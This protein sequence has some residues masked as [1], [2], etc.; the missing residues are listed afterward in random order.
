MSEGFTDFLLLDLISFFVVQ[1]A[2]PHPLPSQFA[3]G[4]SAVRRRERKTATRQISG[5]GGNKLVL[6]PPN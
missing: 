1:H 6:F 4:S 5:I 3:L 2:D